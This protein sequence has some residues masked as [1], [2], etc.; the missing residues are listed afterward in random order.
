MVMVT[1]NLVFIYLFIYL[2]LFI[3]V[4]ILYLYFCSQT[5]FEPEWMVVGFIQILHSSD[6]TIEG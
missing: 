4:S 2:F 5:T 6:H 1:D 3:Y